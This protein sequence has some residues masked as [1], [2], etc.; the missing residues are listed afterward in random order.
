MIQFDSKLPNSTTSIFAIIGQLARKHDAINL[1]QGFP[2]YPIS[3]ELKKWVSHYLEKDKNQYAPMAGLPALREILSKKYEEA[4]QTTIDADSEITIHAGATQAIFMTIMAFVKKDDE[5]IIIEPAYDCYLPTIQ[6][7]KAKPIS[8][9]VTAP[10]YKIDWNEV[11]HKIS[12]KTRMIIINNPHNPIGKT[13]DAD[14]MIT[15]QNLVK[16]KNIIVLSDEVYEH[17]VY[18]GIVHQSILAYPQLAQ[19]SVAIYSFGK[20]FHAT[21]W[22]M[23]YSIA[24]SNLMAEIRNLHQWNVFSVN[25]FLQYAL[26]EFLKDPLEYQKIP[27]FFQGKRDLLE[28]LLKDS[29]FKPLK[30][31]GTYFQL[32]DYSAVSKL[33]DLAF[34]KWL[35]EEHKV[36]TIPLSPFYK[37]GSNDQ[38]VR[39]CFAKQD[40]TLEDAAQRLSRL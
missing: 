18:D 19:Q 16:D 17:L 30:C 21:G 34:A 27:H 13:L 2:D 35:I 22:K 33:P 9:P 14:D 31:S 3:E 12:E 28:R 38:V 7:A 24:P 4:Y 37:N 8:I 5:V 20:T 32:Y 6:L 36:A 40:S 11:K 26:C 25:S 23:G 39:L 29:K 15:L 10:N 1:G